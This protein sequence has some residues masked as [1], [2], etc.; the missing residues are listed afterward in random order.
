M[1]NP[2]LHPAVAPALAALLLLAAPPA[3]ARTEPGV[4]RL[5]VALWP[6]YDQPSVLVIVSLR[7]AHGVPL[8]ATIHLPLPQL[9]GKP[10]AVA[11][12][13]AG[14]ALVVLDY[15]LQTKKGVSEV[16]LSTDTPELQIEYSI[17]LP[18][19]E[20]ERHFTL[21]WP[22]Y[23]TIEQLAV[24]MQQPAGATDLAMWPRPT[25]RRTDERGL[26]YYGAE[27]G[28]VAPPEVHQIQFRYR[29]A[30]QA[31]SIARPP[32]AAA[33]QVEAGPPAPPSAPGSLWPTLL[34]AAVL[35]LACGG[36][37][38]RPVRSDD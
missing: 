23:A 33:P 1:A 11:K 6:E 34:V 35:L 30:D 13:G 3:Q 8:P 14:G 9:V 21:D 29:K 17:D 37:L 24:E 38:F 18:I 31:L 36:W 28:K 27:L 26:T 12:R 10:S 7:L 19:D 16:V 2:S 32:P 20:G 15:K 5:H 25:L 4:K 22:V